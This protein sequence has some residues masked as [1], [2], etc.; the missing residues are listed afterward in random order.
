MRIRSA[1]TV[2]ATSMAIA[3]APIAL[4]GVITV[5]SMLLLAVV[6]AVVISAHFTNGRIPKDRRK[7]YPPRMG[8]TEHS[9]TKRNWT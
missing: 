2:V 7:H 6:V 8:F 3:C 5:R 1:I 4:I 9:S